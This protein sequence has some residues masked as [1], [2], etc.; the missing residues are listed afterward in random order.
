[1]RPCRSNA[2][3]ATVALSVALSGGLLTGCDG[4][5]GGNPVSATA[6]ATVKA[7]LH[8]YVSPSGAVVRTDQGGDTVSEGQG[9]AMLLAYAA[10]DRALSHDESRPRPRLRNDGEF[11]PSPA[12]P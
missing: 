11:P 4:Q 1:M 9:Y 3:V 7:F 5:A 2:V 8:R 10:D 12:V 6:M